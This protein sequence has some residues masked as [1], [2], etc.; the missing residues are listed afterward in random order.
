MDWLLL[1]MKLA[2]SKMTDLV[3]HKPFQNQKSEGFTLELGKG[4]SFMYFGLML[5]AHC[6]LQ[7]TKSSQ[8]SLGR[9]E[10]FRSCIFR[11]PRSPKALVDRLSPNFSRRGASHCPV[12]IPTKI[13]RAGVQGIAKAFGEK[14][15][16]QTVRRNGWTHKVMRVVLAAWER[17]FACPLS[18]FKVMRGFM[19]L[20]AFVFILWKNEG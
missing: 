2:P 12:W 5:V 17:R 14:K 16:G 10:M 6:L 3:L 1:T 11:M 9:R 18:S 8:L 13:S 4:S 19:A 7:P 20:K 15:R